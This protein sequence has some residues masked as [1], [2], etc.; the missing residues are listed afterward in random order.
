MRGLTPRRPLS[1]ES[2]MLFRR[3]PIEYRRRPHRAYVSRSGRLSGILRSSRPRGRSDETGR[4]S[5]P[6]TDVGTLIDERAALCVESLVEEAVDSGARALRCRSRKGA[7]YV[8]TVLIDVSPEMKVG[9]EDFRPV[10]S[11][12]SHTHLDAVCFAYPQ[13][14]SKRA[15]QVRMHE[16]APAVGSHAAPAPPEPPTGYPGACR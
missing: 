13:Q 12:V 15:A 4:S 9:K 10:V 6:E 11:A 2:L 1:R 16:D 14:A 5:G 8:S 7:Q 3:P